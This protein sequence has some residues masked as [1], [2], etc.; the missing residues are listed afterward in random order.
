MAKSTSTEV[1]G[2]SLSLCVS[3]L[4]RSPLPTINDVRF[5]YSS[6]KAQNS[7]D[8]NAVISHYREAYW[9]CAP[10]LGEE[11]ARLFIDSNRVIQPRL[12]GKV[13]RGSGL[14]SNGVWID[15]DK[16]D[17]FVRRNLTKDSRR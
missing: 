16:F 10:D 14:G 2:L 11:I 15:V 12:E 9:Y 17:E 6:T 5:I 8:W 13:L 1:V 4:L 3:S 7:D